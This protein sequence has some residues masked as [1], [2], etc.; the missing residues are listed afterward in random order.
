MS[1][2]MV[3]KVVTSAL[4]LNGVVA[5]PSIAEHVAKN[6]RRQA[7]P[8]VVPFPE[9]PGLPTHALFNGFD[10]SSQLVDVSGDHEY[11]PPG[12][13]DI[14]GPCAGLNSAANHGYISRDGIANAAD[15]TKGLWEAFSLDITAVKAETTPLQPTTASQYQSART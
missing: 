3:A 15:I 14:R 5:F 6:S 2:N 12:K 7:L 9:Y 1:N 13:G 4:L 11:R 10:P 8:A